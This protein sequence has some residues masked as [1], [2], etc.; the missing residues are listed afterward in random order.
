M[1]TSRP[2]VAG[3]S[4]RTRPLSRRADDVRNTIDLATFVPP[5]AHK[6]ADD[7]LDILSRMA[8]GYWP[9]INVTRGW[10]PL[11]VELNKEL[12]DV[13]PNYE[14]FFVEKRDGRLSYQIRVPIH[15]QQ[16]MTAI[17]SLLNYAASRSQF[18]CEFCSQ[19]GDAFIFNHHV[20]I[21]CGQPQCLDALNRY[22]EQQHRVR[23]ANEILKE[24]ANANTNTN[25]QGDR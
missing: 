2:R 21:T 1:S 9:H 23:R 15:E 11:V 16:H 18:I 24:Q 17:N 25:E 3:K 12:S 13:T 20:Q 6:F 10:Y 4:Q 5:D 19:H 8:V 14:V 22:V 7:L